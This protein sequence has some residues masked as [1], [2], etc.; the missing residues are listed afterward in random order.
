MPARKLRHYAHAPSANGAWQAV[1]PAVPAGRALVVSSISIAGTA[2][3]AST[4][5]LRYHLSYGGQGGVNSLLSDQSHSMSAT[6]EVGKG[7]VL[8]EGQQIWVYQIAGDVS[9]TAV[10]VSGLE[11]DN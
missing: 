10:N 2:G 4:N 8:T 9:T 6:A 7:L 11:V 3:S 1:T 5:T